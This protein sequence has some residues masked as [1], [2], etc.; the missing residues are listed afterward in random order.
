VHRTRRGQGHP[1]AEELHTG[2]HV[3]WKSHGTTTEGTVR[4]KIT[5]DAEAS[6]RTVRASK[7]EPQYEVESDKS[8][9][10]AVHKPGALHRD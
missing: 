9:R 2:D 6:G 8:G 3:S 1:M 5:E 10:T 4:R 7:D